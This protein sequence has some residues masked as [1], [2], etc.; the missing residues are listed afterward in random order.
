MKR[1]SQ[2]EIIDKYY[3]VGGKARDY[4]LP[5]VE[6]VAD[7]ARR[8]VE[9]HT[10]L[11]LNADLEFVVNGAMLHDIGCCKV[12]APSIHCFGSFK[13]IMHGFLGAEILRLEG[14]GEYMG[15]CETHVGAGLSKEMIRLHN[16]SLPY[17][18]MLPT[19][20]E[21]KIICYADKF[22]SKS[23][24]NLRQPK[25]LERVRKG[26]LQYGQDSLERFNIMHEMFK[27]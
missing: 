24:E 5:H 8:I 23:S 17:R 9:Q 20:V 25:E 18:D 27:I 19:T 10:E 4:Y 26:M 13:Y 22:F 2:S 3:P 14:L 12:D 21:E 15:V 11:N 6:A 7:F 16:L 1:M